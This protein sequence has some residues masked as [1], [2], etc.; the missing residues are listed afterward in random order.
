MFSGLFE[1]YYVHNII[2]ILSQQILNGKLLLAVISEKN[3][4]SVVVSNYN[5]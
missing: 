1:K 4:I 3:I 2:I 5:R